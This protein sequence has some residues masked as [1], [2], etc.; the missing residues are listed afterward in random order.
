MKKIIIKSAFILALVLLLDPVS[1]FAQGK[2]ELTPFAG[3]QFG[4]KL[5]MYE[6]DIKLQDGMN[7]GLMLD[8]EVAK[9][10]KLE[11]FWSQMDSY[12]EFKPFYNY[13]YLQ[14]DP[15]DMNI[16]Y[17]QI[18]TV[19]EINMDNIR[20]FG[21]FTLGTTYFKPQN[22]TTTNYSDD[23]QFSVTLGGGAKIWLSDRI[24]IRLQGRLMLPMFW[25]GAGFSF[26]TGGSGFTVGA[27]TSMVQGDF[28]GG[29]IIALGD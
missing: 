8:I 5:R 18:G 29:L 2:F 7:Y 21:S 27:G 17:I 25:G 1:T 23:W 28:T 20:P 12:A 22:Q 16:G 26:G 15:V 13:E 3:Y 11:L 4:G 14:V 6:G 9:D 24:G 19:R 10:T